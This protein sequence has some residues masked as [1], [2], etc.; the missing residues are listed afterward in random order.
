MDAQ[1]AMMDGPFDREFLDHAISG[2]TM[3]Q[4]RAGFCAMLEYVREGDT[5]YVYAVDRLGRD[6]IDVQ[7]NVRA[8]L[9]KGVIL[10]VRGLGPIGRGVGEL[11][12]AVLAQMAAMERDRIRERTDAGRR[13]AIRSLQQFGKTHR[14][15]ESLGRPRACDPVELREWRATNNASVAITSRHFGISASTVKRYCLCTGQGPAPDGRG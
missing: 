11:I 3:A 10:H 2:S 14:G 7:T 15:K 5:L 8:L 9:S 13:A 6:A 1:R 4:Q 12:I